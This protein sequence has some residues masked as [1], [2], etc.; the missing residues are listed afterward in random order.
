MWTVQKD[1]IGIL[2]VTWVLEGHMHS[3]VLNLSDGWS[4]RRYVNVTAK[5]DSRW[6]TNDWFGLKNAVKYFIRTGNETHWTVKGWLN[7]RSRLSVRPFNRFGAL[8]TRRTRH[9]KTRQDTT[10]QDEGETDRHPSKDTTQR[11]QTFFLRS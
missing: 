3:R 5:H 6:E 2:P 1:L 8:V 11:R 4:T 7:S 10:R 9:G